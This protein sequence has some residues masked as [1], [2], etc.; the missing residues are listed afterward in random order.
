MKFYIILLCFAFGNCDLQDL[1]NFAGGRG[2]KPAGGGQ[3]QGATGGRPAARPRSAFGGG[4]PQPIAARPAARPRQRSR[5]SPIE[6]PIPFAEVADP[7]RGVVRL[8]VPQPKAT[9]Q[10]VQN[11]YFHARFGA[12]LKRKT[13]L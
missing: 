13:Y 4:N 5:Q 8:D 10:Q 6:A 7:S 11:I 3:T 2:I 9:A 1:I 12:A